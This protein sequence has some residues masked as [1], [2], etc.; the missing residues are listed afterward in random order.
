MISAQP[1]S[2]CLLGLAVGDAVG[3][4]LG[5]RNQGSSV[6]SETCRPAWLCHECSNA[7]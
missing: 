6:R 5:F 3:T 1:Y 4:A 7:A 2:G